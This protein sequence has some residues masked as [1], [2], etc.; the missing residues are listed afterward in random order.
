MR[1]VYVPAVESVGSRRGFFLSGR[2]RSTTILATF[3]VVVDEDIT[4]EVDDVQRAAR[5]RSLK[6]ADGIGLRVVRAIDV[7]MKDCVD[8]TEADGQGERWIALLS[9][10]TSAANAQPSHPPPGAVVALALVQS[11]VAMA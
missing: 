6:S 9:L 8:A 4:M 1:D 3:G 7:M 2:T 11:P 5:G 10:C